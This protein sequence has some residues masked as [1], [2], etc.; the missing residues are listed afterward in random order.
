MTTALTDDVRRA[1]AAGRLA[2]LTTILAA[3][4]IGGVGPWTD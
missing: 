3:D 4:R 2:H 1:M